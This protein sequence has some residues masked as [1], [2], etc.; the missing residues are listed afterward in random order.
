MIN[1]A[2]QEKKTFTRGDG[3]VCYNLLLV[4]NSLKN[5]AW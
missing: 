2:A 3:V 1:D 4:I 5:K